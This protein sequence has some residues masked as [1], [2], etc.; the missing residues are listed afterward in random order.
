MQPNKVLEAAR[1]KLL[2]YCSLTN[3]DYRIPK[4][5]KQMAGI[6]ER[7]ESGELKRVIIT[8][9][10]R[11]GK[12]MLCSQYFPAWY[13]GRN[14]SKY[15]IAATYG[16]DLSDDFG[17]KVRDQLNDS[18]FKTVFPETALRTD[19]KAAARFETTQ[20]GTYFGVGAGGPITGRGAHLLLIDDP[21]KNREE[22]DSEPMRTK[23]YDWYRSVAYTRLM[24]Q[25]AILII[26]T[27]WHE[28][29]LIGQILANENGA[30]WTIFNLKAI[31]EGGKA[32]W[33]EAYDLEALN[34]IRRTVGEYDWSCLYQQE[35]IPHE[36]IIFKPD[37]MKAG[38]AE[39]NEYAAIYAAVDPAIS[40]NET[41]D[42]TA[43]CVVG[44]SYTDP[45]TIHE[46]ETL[47]GHWT[48]EQQLKYIQAVFKKYKVD[49][50]GIEDV[51][52]QKAL[53]QECQ[54]LWI[55]V[56]PLKA[57]RDKVARAMSVSHFFSQGRVRVNTQ[58]TR[59]QMLSFRGHGEKNDLADALIHAVGMVRDFSEERYL[60]EGK[61]EKMTSHQWFYKMATKQ[62]WEGE[63]QTKELTFDKAYAGPSNAD[64]Y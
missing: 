22:A 46:L 56:T 57:N 40:K 45:K 26:M 54:R 17:R 24:P 49:F 1:A 19:S 28:E 27:R 21:I 64:F 60:K 13:M 5:L 8:I 41:A 58:D 31:G 44:I 51:A 14:P 12:S 59:R 55:P 10:P 47:H 6:L 48:F 61:P 37:W 7:V 15:L 9:P 11:H 18:L 63:T 43:I 16:Q 3:Q 23:M 38:L 33:P 30:G 50:F 4:H 2:A 36:G 39:N 34:D 52:Y 25:G 62:E 29:D 53:I 35:P 20:G 42:E 32:L